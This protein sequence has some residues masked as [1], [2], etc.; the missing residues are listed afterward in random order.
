MTS[1]TRLIVA[2]TLMLLAAL[3]Q[4]GTAQMAPVQANGDVVSTAAGVY[5]AA[6]A[7]RG[8]ETYM[9]VCIACH[10]AGTYTTPAFREKWHSKPLSEFFALVSETMPKQEPASLTPKEYVEVLAYLLKINGAP[11][12]KEELPADTAALKKFKIEMPAEKK[13]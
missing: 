1:T 10:P 4:R 12:G 7:V 11:D 6:Q 9:N 5:T 2:C 3:A 13:E 8:E